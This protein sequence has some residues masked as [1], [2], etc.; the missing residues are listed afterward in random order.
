M[1]AVA[2][3]Q[4]FASRSYEWVLEAD[5]SACFDEI[6]HAGLMGRVRRRVGDKR[7]LALVK[8]SLKAGV[9]SEDQAIRENNSAP[10]GGILSPLLA[11][12][13]LEVLDEHFA[14]LWQSDSATRVDRSRRRRHGQPVYRLVRY[15]DDFVVLVSGT[16]EHAEAIR[17]QVA[18]VLT[19]VGLRL[20]PEK[21]TVVHIDE[22]FDF[23][24][25]RI[26]RHPKPGTTRRYDYTFPAKKSLASVKRKV[27][28]ITKEGTNQPLSELLNRLN[29]VL[30]GW[31]SYFQHAV[32]DATFGYLH[33]Y[34]WWRVVGWIRR[35]HRKTNWK[36]LR[37]R[38][39]ATNR[40]WPQDGGVVLFDPA[41]VPITRYRYRGDIP[42]PWPKLKATV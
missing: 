41:R 3:I 34:T 29:L 27:K 31:T 23:V 39:Y 33:H 37:R 4:M 22:G 17:S 18:A 7:V 9:L 8:A 40:W 14:R 36:T 28:A 10:Q 6:N 12:I 5:I 26:Q 25:F 2:E 15:A 38:Y 21:T 11:N 42:T 30:R 1:D 24:G 19:P 16:R 32:A 20:S 35:K 13:A